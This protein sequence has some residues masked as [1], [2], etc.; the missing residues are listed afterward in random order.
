[1]LKN[2]PA[3]LWCSAFLTMLS[4]LMAMPG[5]AASTEKVISFAMT[6]F[7][8]FDTCTRDAGIDITTNRD[9]AQLTPVEYFVE[10]MGNRLGSA[11]TGAAWGKK[12]FMLDSPVAAGA[13][14]YVFRAVKASFNGTPLT[15][16]ATDYGA[17]LAA[18]IPVNAL[19]AGANALV[20]ESCAVP[21]DL[22]ATQTGHSFVSTDQGATWK[23]AAG[24]FLAHLRLYRY[25]ASGAIT[26]DV[27]DLANPNGQNIICPQITVTNLFVGAEAKAPKDTW[28]TLEARSGGTIR[29]DD[30]WSDWAPAKDV[31]PARFLQWRAKLTGKSHQYTPVLEG[32]NIRAVVQITT[33]PAAQGYTVTEFTNP[34]IVRSSFPFTYQEPSD[35]L[36]F[37]RNNW[38]LDAVVAPGKTEME[39]YLLLRNWVRLQWPHNEGN[40]GR[41]WDAINILSAPAGDHGMCVHYGVTFTQ[42][43]LALG[44]NARQII[45]NNHYVSEVWVNDLKKWVL[46]DVEAVQQ[47]GWD[48]YGTAIYLNTDTGKPLN[49]LELHRALKNNTLDKVTQ[50]LSMSDDKITFKPYERTYGPE[51]YGNFRYFCFPPRND[52]LDQLEPWEVQHGVDHYHSNYYY[53]WSDGPVATRGEYSQYSSREGDLYWTLNQAALTLTATNEKNELDVQVDTETPNFKEFRYSLNGAGWQTLEG[54]G[55][56]QTSRT[57]HLT[58][59]L[60]TGTNTLEIKPRSAFGMDGITTKVAIEVK[61]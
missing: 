43:A 46:L 8:Q 47:E 32:V 34:H 27:I 9:A 12:V 35:K 11:G 10:D 55:D 39:K 23:R 24:E 33:D 20:M 21:I 53:W 36:T 25:S 3:I 17:W 42:C 28:I 14:L 18:D 61:K 15:F 1:M 31:K 54:D 6:S 37:L 13:T 7:E 51:E 22:D 48:R 50:V 58:W 2:I 26:S 41:P 49:G 56:G 59:S 16:K 45:L 5:H 30:N 60:R 19:K 38:K 44:Y 52:F 29:P 40:C 57:A 4:M